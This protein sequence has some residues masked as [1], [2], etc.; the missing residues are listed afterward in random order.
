MLIYRYK[1]ILPLRF[2]LTPVLSE[3]RQRYFSGLILQLQ[4][5]PSRSVG[6]VG[7]GQ[8]PALFCTD[9]PAIGH[10]FQ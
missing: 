6:A 4:T 9:Q 5:V 1:K 3:G 2:D 8:Q 7:L 10:G